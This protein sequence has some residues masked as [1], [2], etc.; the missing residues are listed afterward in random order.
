MLSTSLYKAVA[1][2]TAHLL[3]RAREFSDRFQ[4]NRKSQSFLIAPLPQ[5]ASHL[6][7]KSGVDVGSGTGQ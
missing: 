3:E 5:A 6:V 2:T 4:G 1:A 7:P